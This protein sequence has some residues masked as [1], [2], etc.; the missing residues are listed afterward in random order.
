VERHLAAYWA[1]LAEARRGQQI[2]AP[3]KK[4]NRARRKHRCSRLHKRPFLDLRCRF[5]LAH[6]SF[7]GF[8][9]N[10]PPVFSVAVES[11]SVF[12]ASQKLMWISKEFMAF[13]QS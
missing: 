9:E 2:Q 6:N 10:A 12:D 11:D 5:R 8:T 1:A 4:S 13:E 7:D 3:Q